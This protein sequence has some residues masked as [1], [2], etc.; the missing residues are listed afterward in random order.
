MTPPRCSLPLALAL[1]AALAQPAPKCA[2]RSSE[3]APSCATT[4][5]GSWTGLTGGGA[6]ALFDLY[7]ASALAGA[8]ANKSF[9]VAMLHGSGWA[10]GAGSVDV[11]ALRAEL[12]VDSG[13]RL[14]GAV[15]ADCQT[16]AWD[17][18]SVWQRFVS[19]ALPLPRRPLRVHIAPHTHNDVGWRMTYMQYYTGREGSDYGQ[20]VSAILGTVIPAL[21]EDPKRRFSYVEQAYFQLHFERQSLAVQDQ[22]RALVASRQLVFLN[23][24]WSMHDEANPTFVDMLDNTHLGHR[25]IAANFGEDALPELSWQIDPFGHSAFEG[26]LA[27]PLGGFSGVMWAREMQDF[28]A[29]SC[30]NRGLERVWQ[31]SASLGA[32]ASAF[33][34]VFSSFYYCTPFEVERCD[35]EYNP[36][37]ASCA[38]SFAKADAPLLMVDLEAFYA[39]A[40]RGDDVMVLFGDD[41][42]YEAAAP[43]F[44][45]LDALIAE[46]NADPLQRFNASY[47]TPADYVHSKLS[48]S[49]P[50]LPLLGGDLFPY[51]DDVQGHNT[52]SGYFSSR[53]AFKAFVR[54]SSAYLQSARQLQAL[55]ARADG[56]GELVALERALG[57]TQHHD[58][59]AG[60]A[61]QNVNDDYELMLE[62]GRAAAYASISASLARSTGFSAAPF[63]LCPLAN[64][65]RCPALEAGT[66]AVALVHNSLGQVAAAAPVRLVVG[67]PEGVE[68]WAVSDASGSAV[69]AQLVPLSA[70]DLALRTLYGGS[71]SAA[72]AVAWLCFEA[73]LPAAGFSAFFLEPSP[74]AT[75]AP[76]TSASVVAEVRLEGGGGS[77]V[78]IVGDDQTISNGRLTLTAS[79]ATGFMSRYQD[80]AT[81]V[82][83]PL[84]QQWLAYVAAAGQNINGSTQASG[85]YILRPA[86]QAPLPLLPGGAAAALRVVTG[87]VVSF[88]ESTYAYV[89]QEARL[90]ASA[91]A[92]EVAWTI[93]PVNVSD[94]DGREVVT[95]YSVAGLATEGRWH[96][97]ANCREAQPRQRNARRTNATITEPVAANFFPSACLVRTASASATLAVALDRS[98]ASTSLNDGELELLVHRRL[99]ADDGRG[100][101]EPLNEPGLDGKGLVIRGTH[102]VV[103]AP[104]AAA[105]RTYKA[106]QAQALSLPTTVRAFAPLGA[107]SPLQWRAAYR[108]EASLLAAPLPDNVQ[109]V[110]LQPLGGSQLLLR[111]AHAFELGEDASLSLNTTVS[112]AALL[113]GGGGE[114]AIVSAT[115]M[116][117][118]GSRA[119]AS[120]EPVTYRTDGGGSITLPQL[121]QPP[122]G[123]GLSV[124]LVPMA[125]RT[126]MCSTAG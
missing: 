111:L 124:T 97:D 90:W 113:H 99:L 15:S 53:P 106:L 19:P 123:A 120:V 22:I 52:W 100:V 6:T 50:T 75:G 55:A 65:S 33:A 64:V 63:A 36:G 80:S 114:A 102:W 126:F 78:V 66:A 82:D 104:N 87:P 91:G 60:T 77:G 122:S 88:F 4:F 29:Q 67:M 118:P 76:R 47:S 44:E 18:D 49:G 84:A 112:L 117:L 51:N 39:P 83:V 115:D 24:A 108:A 32:A 35:Q 62:G 3:P 92:V 23:G 59:I 93:G 38:A 2:P 48:A 105:P 42:T 72:G 107:L 21:L 89:T 73:R 28:K 110:T 13:V 68:S 26:V 11:A 41:F 45:Y 5:A 98:E 7:N 46:L 119:L 79:A 43:Y 121:P 85:A 109:L 31:P 116:T 17:N 95:R 9:T 12:A 56:N 96:S 54:E 1:G 8:G 94:G 16:I 86:A 34:G 27:S 71:A 30:A 57:V 10:T 74:T 40:N 14:S 103:V 101:G 69:A 61:Q 125:I 58:A 81:G 70:R 20:N 25:Y 37:P